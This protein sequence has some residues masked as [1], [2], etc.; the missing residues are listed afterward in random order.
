MTG[1]SGNIGYALLYRIAA[2]DVFG[3][4]TPVILQLLEIPAGM[5]ALK[6]VE[7]E[8]RDCAFPNIKGYM[9]SCSFIF[10]LFVLT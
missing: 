8:L 5:E 2:G 6:G 9:R 3:P 7:M 1:A 10:V 4:R